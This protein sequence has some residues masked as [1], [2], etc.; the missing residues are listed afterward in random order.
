MSGN[1]SQNG[2]CG[3]LI[4]G[5]LVISLVIGAVLFVLSLVGHPLGLTPSVSEIFDSEKPDG[6]LDRHYDKVVL[7]YVLTA[8][9]LIGA[10]VI[11]LLLLASAPA[12]DTGVS[13]AP[14]VKV[15]LVGA[16]GAVFVWALVAPIGPKANPQGNVPKLVGL[17]YSTAESRLTAAGLGDPETDT[18]PSQASRCRVYQQDPPAGGETDKYGEVTV[19]CNVKVPTVK[20]NTSTRARR[21]LRAAGLESWERNPPGDGDYS[22][23]RVDRYAPTGRVAPDKKIAVWF[24][25]K[26]PKREEPEPAETTTAPDPEPAAVDYSGLNCD[27]IGH[28]YV[29][30]PGSDPE[31]DADSDGVACESQ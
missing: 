26:P 8:V 13:L 12:A 15:A 9:L 21:R 11:G 18:Y 20:G 30:P 6:W 16:W 17:S 31:H 14:A 19:W 28:S 4:V 23:C 7:G 22:R 25:C 1:A 27:E 5:I 29:V 3:T 24:K 2:G 10:V